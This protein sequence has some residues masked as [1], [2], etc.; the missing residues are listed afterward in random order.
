MTI[1]VVGGIKQF[2]VENQ[3]NLS[4]ETTTLRSVNESLHESFQRMLESYNHFSDKVIS[5]EVEFMLKPIGLFIK[6]AFFS[7]LHLLNE[8]S[9]EIITMSVM[10]TSIGLMISPLWGSRGSIWLGRVIAVSLMGSIW[11]ILI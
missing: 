1:K 11:R 9:V 10:G 7:L 2:L 6:D 8:N 5:H 3:G 4:L